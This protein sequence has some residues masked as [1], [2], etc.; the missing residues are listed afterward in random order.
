MSITQSCT[1]RKQTILLDLDTDQESEDGIRNYELWRAGHYD[2]KEPD[3]L[4]WID[5]HFNEGDT[6]YDIGA[7]IGQYSLYAAKC[8]NG[9][10][11]I[12]TFEPEALN[13]S[14]LNRNIVLNELGQ[15][16]TA[17]P[18]AVSD[19]TGIDHFYSKAFK[20]G[21]ALHALGRAVTQGEKAFEPQNRQ[22]I[23]AV[24]LDD[25]T[26]K[27]DLPFPTHIK[28]DVDGIEDRIVSGAHN[29]LRDPRLKTFLIEVYMHGE[30]AQNIQT[31]FQEAGLTLSNADVTDFTPGVVQNLIFVRE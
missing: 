22:G 4:D 31:A 30:I 3:T 27:F 19:D 12:L 21:A 13:F 16:M 15:A 10:A 26:G 7:N 8:L 20:T 11:Q 6:L 29:T 14:K 9:N 5:A 2:H 25:L 18:I 24:S 17:Y 1:V 28:V 23:M